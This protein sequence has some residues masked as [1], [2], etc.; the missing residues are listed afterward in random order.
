MFC[1][2]TLVFKFAHL[3][4]DSVEKFIHCFIKEAYLALVEL[5]SC[6]FLR[7][8]PVCLNEKSTSVV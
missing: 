7:F 8:T 1:E 2:N 6:D 4:S 5:V 3:A